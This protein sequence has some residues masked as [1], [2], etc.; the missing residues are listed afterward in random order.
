MKQVIE[1]LSK[2]VKLNEKLLTE[3]GVYRP[4]SSKRS[5]CGSNI[6][7]SSKGKKGVT[8]TNTADFHS[9]QS[10]SEIIPR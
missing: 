4:H 9:F 6:T 1:M 2:E 10:V 7:T 5:S 8:S 3:P